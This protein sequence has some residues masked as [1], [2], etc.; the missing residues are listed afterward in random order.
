[1]PARAA[2][3]IPWQGGLQQ[4]IVSSPFLNDIAGV[5]VAPHGDAEVLAT[6]RE[7]YFDRTYGRY[8]SHRNTPNRL[9]VAEH[10]AAVRKG[11]VVYLAHPLGMI[12]HRGGARVHR[13][14]FINALRLLHTRP[15]IAA[16]L[17]SAGRVTLM[18]Q[19]EQRR[20]IA[21]LMYAPPLQ[22]G[23]C[24][25][26]EDLPALHDVALTVRVPEAV[27]AATLAPQGTTLALTA[28]DGAL[29]MT[30]P[31]VVGHQAV[32]LAYRRAGRSRRAARGCA[33]RPRGGGAAVPSTL[34][35]GAGAQLF[36]RVFEEPVRRGAHHALAHEAQLAAPAGRV[37]TVEG[38]LGIVYERIVGPSLLAHT[39]AH[40]WRARACGRVLGELHAAL[41][42][43]AGEGLMPLH[44][45]VRWNLERAPGIA[46]ELRA[47]LLA[48]L[49]ALPEGEVLCHGDL[50]PD[51]GC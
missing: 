19:P 39:R 24:M 46:A 17:P 22:R 6:I 36:T 8:C 31:L 47:D 12:Y 7:P 49:A 51:N 13:E 21:H 41:H 48:R 3:T 44:D 27:T 11:N 43:V 2:G 25:V 16:E 14:L 42:G 35:G 32:V 34:V 20:Y 30:A 37:A 45:Y 1:M 9:E 28:V 50:H 18:H 4:G 40:L 29:R 23:N 38:R 5:R 10:P 26:I 33:E 15:A